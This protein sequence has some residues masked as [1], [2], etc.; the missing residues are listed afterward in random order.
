MFLGLGRGDCYPLTGECEFQGGGVGEWACAVGAFMVV[1]SHSR[2]VPA[3]DEEGWKDEYSVLCRVS[4]QKKEKR[5]KS[6]EKRQREKG[7]G[8]REKRKKKW[9]KRISSIK[10]GWFGNQSASH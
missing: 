7:K 3:G 8:K 9:Y 1:R 6:E 2:L 10:M 4:V 5:E